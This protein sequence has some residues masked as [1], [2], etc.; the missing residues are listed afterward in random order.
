MKK[1]SR[2]TLVLAV[3]VVVAAVAAIGGYAY[4]TT[5]GT[6]SGTASVG[7][8]SNLTLAGTAASTVYPGTSS[9]VSFTAN[10]TSPGHQLLGTIYLA[11]VQAY[12]TA[13][14]RTNGT[15]VIGGCGSV[16]P[17]NV[18]NAGTSDYY[19]ADVA[20]NQDFGPSGSPQAVT[21]GGTLVMNNLN[22]S[23]DA[24]KGAF[25]KLNLATR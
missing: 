24:C 1:H 17:G 11:S 23:Q 16:D 19:M 15:N 14:D 25:L 5:T 2:R 7:T 9:A 12:P 6:G 8:S 21:A 22:A 4:F 3:L 18:G 13:L 10:N 20:A